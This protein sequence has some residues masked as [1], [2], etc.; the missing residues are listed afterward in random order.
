MEKTLNKILKNCCHAT[1]Y[2]GGQLTDELMCTHRGLCLATPLQAESN[3]PISPTT[4]SIMWFTHGY[5]LQ[6]NRDQYGKHE[7]V[8]KFT[9]AERYRPVL[10]TDDCA[11]IYG[12]FLTLSK[13]IWVFRLSQCLSLL[14]FYKVLHWI[15]CSL[16]ATYNTKNYK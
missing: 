10:L 4:S 3:N 8:F 15:H 13:T 6:L 2:G 12:M 9:I 5:W 11:E 16:P 7:S 1:S 14:F